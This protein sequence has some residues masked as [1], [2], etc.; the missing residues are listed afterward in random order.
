MVITIC[1]K[2][3]LWIFLLGYILH[4]S[5]MFLYTS[6]KQRY[7][8]RSIFLRYIQSEQP[9]KI[10]KISLE[11]ICEYLNIHFHKYVN[12]KILI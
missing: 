11:I 10:G 5:L 4:G 2:V 6:S 12:L 8:F 9:W 1:K 7:L 3:N